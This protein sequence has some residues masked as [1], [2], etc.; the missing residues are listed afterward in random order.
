M[1]RL[2]AP[3]NLHDADSSAG[4]RKHDCACEAYAQRQTEARVRRREY[5]TQHA[6]QARRLKRACAEPLQEAHGALFARAER[7][8]CDERSGASDD[9]CRGVV[10]V[11]RQRC[12]RA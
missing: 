11:A 7:G 2:H 8:R 1:Q 5:T 4:N 3:S 10:R 12:A 6:L 9:A